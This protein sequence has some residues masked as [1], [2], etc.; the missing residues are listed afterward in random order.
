LIILEYT[1]F[2]GSKKGFLIYVFFII[3]KHLFFTN[4]ANLFFYFF[5]W[6]LMIMLVLEKSYGPKEAVSLAGLATCP[7]VGWLV[8]G[9]LVIDAIRWGSVD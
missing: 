8:I 6:Y 1:S 2:E 7:T 4:S 3:S 5:L 9:W